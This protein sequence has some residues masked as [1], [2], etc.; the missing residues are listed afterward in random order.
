MGRLDGK[1]GL[2]TGGAS[3]LGEG[4]ARRFVEDGARVVIT[5][6]D[7]EGTTTRSELDDESQ[8]LRPFPWET[9]FGQRWLMM[10]AI[11][12]GEPLR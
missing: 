3:G 1:V 8:C 7:D 6:I 9:R 5:D 4:T 2:I 12:L 10:S 11:R